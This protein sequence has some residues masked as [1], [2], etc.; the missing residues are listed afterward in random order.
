[1]DRIKKNTV[2]TF[3]NEVLDRNKHQRMVSE[4]MVLTGNATIIA[5]LAIIIKTP[6]ARWKGMHRN[7]E[8]TATSWTK[9][10]ANYDVIIIQHLFWMQF[11]SAHSTHSKQGIFILIARLSSK[12]EISS[13][14]SISAQYVWCQQ[15]QKINSH[16]NKSMLRSILD[17]IFPLARPSTDARF[18]TDIFTISTIAAKLKIA[19]RVLYNS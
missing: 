11:F 7:R 16:W 12:H 18:K 10:D 2:L 4:R 15:G 17:I 5:L 8:Y 13:D 3:I 6:D 19:K 9:Y 1:M 14:E